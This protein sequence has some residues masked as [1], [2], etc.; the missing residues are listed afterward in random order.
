MD[1]DA[2]GQIPALLLQQWCELGESFHSLV[3]QFL[4]LAFYCCG[5]YLGEVNFFFK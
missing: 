1:S 4:V 2:W 3:P 5:K